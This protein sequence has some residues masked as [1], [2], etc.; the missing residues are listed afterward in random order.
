MERLDNLQEMENTS[1]SDI[2]KLR[3]M[4]YKNKEIEFKLQD[5]W[6]FPRNEQ[7]HY[8]D[9]LPH[10]TCLYKEINPEC[11]VHGDNG[12]LAVDKGKEV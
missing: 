5:A 2:A 3:T 10:C 9:E 1:P 12:W 4:A 6:G 8:W 11:I 7:K